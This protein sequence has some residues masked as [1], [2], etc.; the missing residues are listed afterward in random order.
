MAVILSHVPGYTW[1]A[2]TPRTLAIGR[3]HS[4]LPILLPLHA[5]N[6]GIS[7]PHVPLGLDSLTFCLYRLVV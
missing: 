7:H 2:L 4:C 5:H 3:V 6:S 1:A